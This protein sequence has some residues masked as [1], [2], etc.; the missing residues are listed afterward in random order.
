MDA[1]MRKALIDDPP[2]LLLLARSSGE[3]AA[4]NGQPRLSPFHAKELTAEWFA[5]FDGWA[6]RQKKPRGGMAPQR[7]TAPL[8][9][10]CAANR[11]AHRAVRRP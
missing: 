6:A 2:R 7:T 10:R 9:P 3:T 4:E 11:A 5:G 1:E 8:D